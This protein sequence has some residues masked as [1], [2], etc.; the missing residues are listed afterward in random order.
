M[1]TANT[2]VLIVGAGPTGLL[3]A[4]ELARRAISFRIIDRAP[5]PSSLSRA[6][7]I[8]SRSLEILENLGLLPSLLKEGFWL[9]GTSI[10]RDRELLR[11]I[12]LDEKPTDT[13]PYPTLL[14]IDQA[15]V[16]HVFSEELKRQGIEIERNCEL[17]NFAYDA[18]SV[19]ATLSENRLLQRLKCR[20]LVGCDGPKSKVR[21]TLD[22]DFVGFAYPKVY[23]IAEVRMNW[24]MPQEMYRFLS[25]SGDLLAIPLG[26][27]RFRLTAWEEDLRPREKSSASLHQTLADPPALSHIQELVDRTVPGGVK[28]LE[29]TALMRYKM[30]L[31][32]ASA[33]RRGRCFIAG[34][35]CHVHPPTGSQ[36]LNT[37]IQDAYNLGWKLASVVRGDC[38]RELLES[39]ETERRPIG[40]WVLNN[41]HLAAT[42]R[43]EL[44]GRR[45][46]I[47]GQ[48]FL[49]SR[50]SHLSVNYRESSIVAQLDSVEDPQSLQ[51]GDRI[52]DGTLQAMNI[53]KKVRVFELLTGTA[54]HLLV[55]PSTS[56]EDLHQTVSRV[57]SEYRR[58][59]EI[60]IIGAETKDWPT[61]SLWHDPDQKVRKAYA[62]QAPTLF[63]V[64]PDGYLGARAGS[65]MQ[66]PF[67]QYLENCFRKKE[68]AKSV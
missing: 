24:N 1:K 61:D 63:L 21:E 30:E 45:F 60:H 43:F 36:G 11:R 38:P 16:E 44:G 20:Y 59:I 62:V 51:A 48:K 41:T 29:A 50:W 57:A 34:D 52:P 26:D 46:F 47:L 2:E 54:H 7:G 32:L 33:Y 9:T 18:G 67:L 28:V 35:A 56:E 53:S 4:C 15:R 8:Q 65:A 37:G 19:S 13:E 27:D 66:Q 22:I 14:M 58:W 31:R 42:S 10:Y 3:L 64:R 55:F 12:P 25:D 49:M 6:L 39:Y 23:T 68:L 5:R 40:H 17:K